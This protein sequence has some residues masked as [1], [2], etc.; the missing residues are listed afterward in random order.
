LL[1]AARWAPSSFNEQPWRFVVGRRG[2]DDAWQGILDCLVEANQAWARRAP[3]L[4]LSVANTR[5]AHGDKPNAH[6]WHDTGQATASLSLQATAMGLSV[7]QMAGFS[8]AEARRRFAIPDVFEPVACLAVGRRGAADVADGELAA[9]DAAPRRRRGIDT[10][11]SG[12][13]WGAFPRGLL[14]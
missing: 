3:V 2:D 13:T 5:F 12:A 7:H 11:V 6:A 14:E 8:A 10:F 9:R 1:E 4:M